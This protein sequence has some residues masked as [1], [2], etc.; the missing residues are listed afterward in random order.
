M[1]DGHGSRD[2][3]VGDKLATGPAEIGLLPAMKCMAHGTSS[4]VAV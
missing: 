2:E 4:S 1:C 3:N